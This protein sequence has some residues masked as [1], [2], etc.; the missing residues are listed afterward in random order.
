MSHQDSPM[1]RPVAP[2]AALAAYALADPA[3][4][5]T[6]S[7]AQNESAFPPSPKVALAGAA[8]AD[9]FHRPRAAK[10]PRSL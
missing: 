8:G 4:P 9:Q 5:G 3:P 10:D 1:I 7:L 2:V 6:V